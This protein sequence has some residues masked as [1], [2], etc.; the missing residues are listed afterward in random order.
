MT[1]SLVAQI[2]ALSSEKRLRDAILGGMKEGIIVVDSDRRVLLCNRSLRSIL[3]MTIAEPAGRP[4]VEVVRDTSVVDAFSTALRTGEEVRTVVQIALAPPRSFELTVAPLTDAEGARVGVLG[5]FFD[6]TKLTALE[7]VRREFMADVSHELRTPLTSVKAFV[8][9]L[10]SGGMEDPENRGRF[11]DIVQKNADRMEAILDDLTDLSRIETGAIRLEPEP[12]ELAPLVNEL[13]ESLRHRTAARNLQ[14]TVEVPEGT[15]LTADRRRL[16]QI[17][18]NLADNAI[19]FNRAGGAVR[20]RASRAEAS[21]GSGM[22]R[23]EVE[24]TGNGIPTESIEKVFNRF[25]RVDRSRSREEGGTGLGL[26]IVKHLV[27]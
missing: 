15:F 3:P 25:Y 2:G 19:K 9:T 14:V 10:L 24:D 22:L 11:L 20:L 1:R 8:E 18:L 7:G 26:A 23:I 27:K 13:F 12:I 6:I 4:L 5:I 17:L 21:G 16:E